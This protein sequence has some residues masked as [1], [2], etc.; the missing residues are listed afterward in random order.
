MSDNQPTIEQLR[1]QIDIIDAKIASLFEKRMLYTNEIG[2]IK[3]RNN[4]QTL[5]TKREQ[6][7]LNT[8]INLVSE[9]YLTQFQ[10]ILK[11]IMNASRESQN[12]LKADFSIKQASTSKEFQLSLLFDPVSTDIS[13]IV[14]R[15]TLL[16]FKILS[17]T[18]NTTV[19]KK[20]LQQYGYPHL[21][22]LQICLKSDF[23][24]SSIQRLI[25]TFSDITVSTNIL[26]IS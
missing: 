11:L 2:R 25:K 6:N 13:Q 24:T 7:K 17:I 12:A 20:L 23:D 19:D 8:A 4:L 14:D 3:D 9:E 18:S 26:E 15:I 21:Q 22:E 10:A 5:D 16:G 1:D